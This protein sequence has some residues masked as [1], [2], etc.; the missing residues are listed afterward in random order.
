MMGYLAAAVVVV[1]ISAL[2]LRLDQGR[3]LHKA[4]ILFGEVPETVVELAKLVQMVEL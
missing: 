1:A 4:L 2:L 3:L